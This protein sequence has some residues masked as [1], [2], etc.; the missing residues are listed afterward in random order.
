MYIAECLLS[1]PSRYLIVALVVYIQKRRDSLIRSYAYVQGVIVAQRNRRLGPPISNW[2][3]IDRFIRWSRV[4]STA[5]C[6]VFTRCRHW[7]VATAVTHPPRRP[8]VT[9]L[10]FPSSPPWPHSPPA[11]S[12][13]NI[14]SHKSPSCIIYT[15]E[16]T[17]NTLP[18]MNTTSIGVIYGRYEGYQ[19][20]TFWTEGYSTVPLTFQDEKVKN[21]LSLAVNRS[22]LRRLSTIKPFSTGAPSR[23]PL[24]ELMTLSET[25][26]SD[27]E[28]ILP[29]YFPPLSLRTHGRL[30]LLLNRYP[31]FLDQSYAPDNKVLVFSVNGL[32]ALYSDGEMCLSHDETYSENNVAVKNN[33]LRRGNHYTANSVLNKTESK[34]SMSYKSIVHNNGWNDMPRHCA[35]DQLSLSKVTFTSISGFLYFRSDMI[36]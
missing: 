28:G 35:M 17:F 25:P 34:L 7:Y 8:P 16:I 5:T 20:P 9:Y 30:V 15:L 2:S 1:R 3:L 27:E 21:L 18:E 29:P 13:S 14:Y 10:T 36:C 31:H 6:S 22:D 4:Y 32:I 19:Y 24:R 33:S 11:G 26:E 12:L 23:T